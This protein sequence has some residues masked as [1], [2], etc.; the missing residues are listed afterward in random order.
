MRIYQQEISTLKFLHWAA[1][2]L[3]CSRVL[4]IFGSLYISDV[5]DVLK[6]ITILP[7]WT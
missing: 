3:G 6:T 5:S 4:E 1:I 7:S 2:G